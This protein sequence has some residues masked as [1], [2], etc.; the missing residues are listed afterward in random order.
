MLHHIE[1]GDIA[2]GTSCYARQSK[3]KF[4]YGKWYES[5]RMCWFWQTRNLVRCASDE[6]CEQKKL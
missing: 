4:M 5:F 1:D 3:W 6:A 2:A